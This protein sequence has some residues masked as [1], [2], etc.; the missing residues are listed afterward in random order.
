MRYD[1]EKHHRRSIRLAGHNYSRAGWYY[2]TVCTHDKCCLLGTVTNGQMI[3]NEYG[4]IVNECWWKISAKFIHA[5]LDK[6]II[7]PNHFHGIIQITNNSRG[8]ATLKAKKG[9]AK[10]KEG[11][12]CRGP[13]FGGS[14]A[15]SLSTIV[16]SFKSAVTKRINQIRRT[17]GGKLW[18]R[19]YYE[20]IIR[21]YDD[22][23]HIRNYIVNNPA[24]WDKDENYATSLYK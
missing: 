18:Q 19:N 7:M 13:T 5:K 12:A 24:N 22:Y 17:P 9:T 4:K 3:L 23:N 14:V 21:D 20:H 15:G 6:Y 16:G 11:T 10:A 2:V 1:S 8:T